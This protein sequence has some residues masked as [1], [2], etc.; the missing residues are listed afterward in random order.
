MRHSLKNPVFIFN[1]K[2]NFILNCE[3]KVIDVVKVNYKE[4][5]N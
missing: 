2:L 3:Q 4:R 1:N 5:G